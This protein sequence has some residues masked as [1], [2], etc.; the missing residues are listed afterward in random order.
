MTDI[1]LQRFVIFSVDVRNNNDIVTRGQKLELYTTNRIVYVKTCE[2]NK[3]VAEL[4]CVSRI[5]PRCHGVNCIAGFLRIYITLISY[6]TSNI[7]STSISVSFAIKTLEN[8]DVA[9]TVYPFTS[10]YSLP[11]HIQHR[12]SAYTPFQTRTIIAYIYIYIY[13]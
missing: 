8:C 2:I 9:I 3:I 5:L 12:S 6:N 4:K 13:M 7:H 11:T 1:I 10:F